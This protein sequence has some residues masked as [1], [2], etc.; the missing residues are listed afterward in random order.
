[1]RARDRVRPHARRIGGRRV[2]PDE[3]RC[4]EG[5]V[6][7]LHHHERA[8]PG[9]D[10]RDIGRELVDEQILTIPVRVAHD[11]LRCP[12]VARAGDGGER[13]AGHEL[14]GALVLESRRRELVRRHD[15]GNTLHVD[16]DVNLEGPLRLE[17]RPE[18]GKHENEKAKSAH[19]GMT[20]SEDP[21]GGESEYAR[22]RAVGTAR[23][24]NGES[25]SRPTDT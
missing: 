13:L 20:V 4:I 12:R 5:R 3:N 2:I 14:A 11:D 25:P 8:R 9:T 7:P 18:R 19:A 10:D 23:R 22:R 17:G 6:D 21:N 1:M 24:T 15:S 16:G